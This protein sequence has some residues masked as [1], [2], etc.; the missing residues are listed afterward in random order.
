MRVAARSR[1]LVGEE[2]LRL[3]FEVGERCRWRREEGFSASEEL[4]MEGSEPGGMSVR[5]EGAMRLDC[6]CWWEGMGV[7]RDG[8]GLVSSSEERLGMAR[9]Q[10]RRV[11]RLARRAA[12]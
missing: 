11:E 12:S 8:G 1:S 3:G 2:D 9:A 5:V 7:V 6:G 4:G 10:E